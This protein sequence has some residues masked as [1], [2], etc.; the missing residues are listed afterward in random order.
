MRREPFL[1]RES[2][3]TSGAEMM[4]TVNLLVDSLRGQ[5]YFIILASVFLDVLGVPG[6]AIPLLMVG[7]S[8]AAT[9]EMSMAALI[10]SATL[11]SSLGDAIWYGLGRTRSRTTL[12]L[13]AKASHKSGRASWCLRFLT[14]HSIAFLLISKFL[15]GIA[16]IAPP[17][18][19][20]ISMPITKFLLFDTLGRVLWV[21]SVSCL[22]YL[23]GDSFS[24][25]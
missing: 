19:G 10:L 12:K 4:E 8:L 14:K 13:L 1:D 23:A 15:P 7:G 2:V 3:T 25:I 17:A 6:T 9:G 22:G 16:T 11:A 24:W 20:L 18:A 5:E 21:S